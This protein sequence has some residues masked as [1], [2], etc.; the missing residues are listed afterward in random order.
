[1]WKEKVTKSRMQLQNQW[2]KINTLYFVYLIVQ[3]TMETTTQFQPTPAQDFDRQ[4]D[5]RLNISGQEYLETLVTAITEHFATGRIKYVLMSGVEIG[6]RPNQND[7]Q[8]EHVHIALILHDRMTAQAIMKKWDV[9]KALGYYFKP[10]NRDL[11]YDGWKNHHVKPFSKKDP[12]QLMI[13]ERG[14][15]PS[16][17]KRK[18]TFT[19]RSETEKKMKTDDV[20]RDI[21]KLVEEGKADQAFEL[22]PR[23]FMMFGEKIKAMVS[24][25]KKTFFGKHT[26]PH[27]YVYG[28]PGTG[29]TSIL[30]FLYPKTYKKDLSNRFWDLYD[31]E[32]FTHVMLEDLDSPTLDRLSVQWLKTICDEAGFTIDQKYKTPQPTRATILVTSNQTVNQ[33]IDGLD[34]VKCIEDTKRALRRRFF[35]IRIDELLKLCGLALIPEYERKQ[36]KKSGNEDPSKLFMSWNYIMDAP[37]GE[38]LKDPDYY[39]Q[40]I[41]DVYYK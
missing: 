25:K 17:G 27:L 14:E 19:L 9:N 29:K 22:Y 33:L 32:Q 23:N 26:D 7:Y 16:D 12:N 18:A 1:M 2:K 13:L 31:E 30:K 41:R 5:I 8:V 21:R 11:P 36:L 38:P 34:E 24:Q 37:T 4:W 39:Q 10:R 35:H 28:F 20:I 3:F 15:L 40:L 6:T